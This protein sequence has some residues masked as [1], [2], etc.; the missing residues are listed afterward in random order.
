M[1]KEE[2]LPIQKAAAN[3]LNK[4]SQT[5]ERVGPPAEGLGKVLT[6]PH[7]KSMPCCELFTSPSDLD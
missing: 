3:V 4:H 1:Q 6:T 2:Q 7:C 5:A